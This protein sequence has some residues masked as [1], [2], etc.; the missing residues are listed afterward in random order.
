LILAIA[1]GIAISKFLFILLVL[2]VIVALVG[3]RA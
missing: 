1:G 2:A 3:A